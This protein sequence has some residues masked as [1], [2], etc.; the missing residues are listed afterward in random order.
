M[1]VFSSSTQH[2]ILNSDIILHNYI[3]CPY[4][5]KWW[6]SI[7]TVNDD[8]GDIFV[9]FMNNVD[10]SPSFHWPQQDDI[11]DWSNNHQE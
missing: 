9:K 8:N 10:T 7:V 5:G 6:T 4:I 2:L 3:A 1:R 11:W